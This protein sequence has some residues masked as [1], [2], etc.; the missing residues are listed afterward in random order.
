[1]LTTNEWNAYD[2]ANE[3]LK[4]AVRNLI[5]QLMEISPDRVSGEALQAAR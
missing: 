3:A 1:M 4:L 2:Q 5:A